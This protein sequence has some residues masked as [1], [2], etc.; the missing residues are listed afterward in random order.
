MTHAIETPRL[1]LIPATLASLDG[2]L[3]GHD[4]LAAALDADVPS[5]WPPEFLDEP[6]LRFMRAQLEAHPD[7][8]P[9]WMWFVLLTRATARPLLI[10]TGGYKGPPNEAG[11]VE[12][13]YGIVS[14]QHRRGYASE[15]A[16]GLITNAFADPRVTHVTAETLT[17]GVASQG[18]L[19]VCRFTGPE[20]GS[21]PGVVRFELR[22]GSQR[23]T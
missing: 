11:M 17:D 19:R 10:G 21:E 5:T 3:A 23:V 12:I 22:R 2:A 7:E 4:A 18:V 15:A 14:D 20:P 9:W 1:R 8:A 6:A 16:Q 13:G